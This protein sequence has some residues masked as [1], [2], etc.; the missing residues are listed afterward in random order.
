MSLKRG[1]WIDHRGHGDMNEDRLVTLPQLREFVEGTTEVEFRRCGKDE[2]RYR[3]IE[4]VL[5]RIRYGRLKRADNGLSCV[6]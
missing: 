3:H 6:T 2:D 5:R 4:G 1:S